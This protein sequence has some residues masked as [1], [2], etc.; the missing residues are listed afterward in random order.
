MFA[1]PTNDKEVNVMFKYMVN[2]YVCTFCSGNVLV[3]A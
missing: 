1:V 3:I 2:G